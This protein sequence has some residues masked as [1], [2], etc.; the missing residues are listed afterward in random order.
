MPQR[1]IDLCAAR[2]ARA[3]AMREPVI[4]KWDEGVSFTLP[5]ELPADF[6]L[7]AQEG[8]MRGALI[9]LLGEQADEF[10]ALRPSMDDINE[11]S[12]AA[13]QVY[14]IAP[15]ESNASARS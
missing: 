9:V 13:G 5:V 3:E 10:F 12:E 11:L 7:L 6:A 8:N 15:G 1:I 14:G 2:A 4:M